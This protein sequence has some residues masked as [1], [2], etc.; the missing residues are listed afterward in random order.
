[1]DGQDGLHPC[2]LHGCTSWSAPLLFTN[3]EG[4][5][6]THFI[7]YYLILSSGVTQWTLDGSLYISRGQRFEIRFFSLLIFFSSKHYRAGTIRLSSDTIRI[8]IHAM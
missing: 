7:I 6:F 3:P 5:F 2:C 1:M 8:A 4:R